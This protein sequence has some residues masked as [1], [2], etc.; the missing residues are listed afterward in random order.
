MTRY[1]FAMAMMIVSGLALPASAAET[2][3]GVTFKDLKV[4]A[5]NYKEYRPEKL[6]ER[7]TQLDG[8]IVRIKGFMGPSFK[9]D[10]ITQ[11]VL[12]GRQL[13]KLGRQPPH[14]LVRVTLSEG[15]TTK[16][17]IKPIVVEGRFQLE[18]LKLGDKIFAIYK[19]TSARVIPEKKPL[20]R[21]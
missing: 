11:F 19:M 14:D 17:M 20:G 3:R 2:V 21:R 1:S 4:D 9:A 12:S 7:I 5:K 8:K 16:F 13:M 10:G 15:M 6:A 18:E